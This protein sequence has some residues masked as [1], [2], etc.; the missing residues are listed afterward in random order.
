MPYIVQG[1]PSYQG[2]KPDYEKENFDYEYPNDLDLKPGSKFHDTLAAK[3]YRRA[4]ES[5]A[6]MSA[7]YPSWR[8]MDQ[9]LTT[10]IPTDDA[11][12]K[13][14]KQ[15]SRKPIS[16]VFPYTY[17]MLEA[18][19]TYMTMAFFQ[20]PIFR[21]EGVEDSDTIGAL[22]LENV[23]RLHCIK[24]KV[25]LSLHTVF[26]DAFAYGIGVGLPG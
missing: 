7:R 15:D 11:E 9:V 13:L 17:S 3:I 19:L 23:I 16:I 12:K 14:K 21:Y 22:L 26:R 8:K 18:L 2:D 1:E 20:D 4:Q 25:A 24:T 5:R 6:E 10:Y